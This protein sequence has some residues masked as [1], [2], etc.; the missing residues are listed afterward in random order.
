MPD[1]SRYVSDLNEA[2]LEAVTYCDGPSLVVA[3]AGS[4]KTRV[5][6]YKIAYLLQNGLQPWNI[7]A[8]TFTNKAAR[9]MNLRISSICGDGFTRYLWSGTFHSIFA[10]MLR[11]EH[12]AI[13][14]PADFTIYN[15][16]D[17]RSLIKT[18]VKDLALDDKVYKPATVS[19]FISEA[20]NHVIFPEDYANDA[21]IRKRDGI[22][23]VPQVGK[24]YAI[25]QARLRTAKAMDF[26]DLL[27]N[28]YVLLKKNPEICQRYRERFQYILVDE[29]QDTNKLQH[30]ILT[31]LTTPTS[32]ICV[33]GDD[34][35]S[36]Y[37]FRGADISNILDFQKHYPSARLI[38]LECNYR[39]TQCIVEAANSIIRHN[40]H[41]IPK[42]VYAA[43]EEGD[44]LKVFSANS[45]KEEAQ[46]VAMRLT[47]LHKN[48][49]D[50]NDIA[51]LYR[52]NAQS[53]SF[54]E[55]FK[56]FGIPY[57]IYGGL[58]FYQR[59]EIMD[60]LAYCRLLCNPS[61]EEAFRRII[62]YPARGIGAATLNKVQHAAAQN[63]V[64]LWDVVSNPA[65]YGVALNA[66]AM[67]KLAGFCQ[68]INS[69]RE[70][71][72]TATASVMV[73]S[74]VKASGMAQD[75]T[76]QHT[77]DDIDRQ[78]NVDELIGSIKAFEKDELTESGKN[79]VSLS[80]FLSTV[81]L[82]TDTDDKT[83][84]TPHVSFMTV[85]AAKGLEFDSIFVT[86]MEH[87]LFPNA[88]ASHDLQEMAE[89]RRLFYVAVTRAKQHCFLS[90]AATRYRYGQMQ[91]NEPS[92]FLEEIDEKYVDRE[93]LDSPSK[94]WG[95]SRDKFNQASSQSFN[96]RSSRGSN[97]SV[98]NYRAGDGHYFQKETHN[99]MRDDE[100]SDNLSPR[101]SSYS[102]YDDRTPR[103]VA[104]Q[105]PPSNFKRLATRSKSGNMGLSGSANPSYAIGTRIRHERFG[106]G[107]IVGSEG[108]GTNEK[109][110][111]EFDECGTKNL[112]IKYARFTLC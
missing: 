68:L 88:S 85:H 16:S 35:Q 91:F 62:N 97:D 93:D 1:I 94:L 105:I 46:K 41:Q 101:R 14:Y 48:G 61:D 111:V 36:I 89:E 52:T 74:V 56:S 82:L 5:L 50:Y 49:V 9:E 19:C 75:L 80:D 4:G 106:L 42:K 108:T 27:L 90:Y 65:L 63:D 12:D 15:S 40:V 66:G 18:I 69:L 13:G 54:E 87:D 73:E 98:N 37:G 43:G 100:L 39:S 72:A 70:H 24:I 67:K 17:S 104:P 10:R 109:I 8:L 26:D 81:S 31:Q 103:R 59:K 64:S 20:K 44:R 92:S 33:V 107:T 102:S 53:R 51:I 25:Y 11:M 47:K 83:D 3:G 58:S 96:S 34:A 29:Y 45:D 57:R 38:K 2:Q 32:R 84:N 28:T 79:F 21:D 60:T 71:L 78:Q 76:A 6:T 30:R 110:L 99:T 7:L 55:I 86:G 112:L 23:N 22:N 95:A 77:A